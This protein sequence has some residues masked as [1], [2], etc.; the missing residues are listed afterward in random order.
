MCCLHD[1][2]AEANRRA[3]DTFDAQRFERG[4]DADDVD[5]RVERA[6]LVQLDVG[7]IDAV[8]RTFDGSQPFE[9][10]AGPSTHP[11]GEVG[12]IEQCKDL[13]RRAM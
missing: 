2:A 9:D 4:A 6:H 1:A 5:D 12:C 13:A 8:N 3:H 10:G 11:V 7:R